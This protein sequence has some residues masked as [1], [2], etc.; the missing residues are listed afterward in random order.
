MRQ[1]VT[2]TPER[3]G[4]RE[5][6]HNGD[7]RASY[8]ANKYTLDVSWSDL[9][10]LDTVAIDGYKAGKWIKDF[11]EATTGTVTVTL[12][13]DGTDTSIIGI[14]TSF[15]YTVKQRTTAVSQYD[16][17]DISMSIEEV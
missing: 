16:L 2:L 8:V 5:R 7:M 1:P 4:N 12:A 9:P 10:S 11:Y 15:S 17:V 6:M 3:I 13:Y 14:I